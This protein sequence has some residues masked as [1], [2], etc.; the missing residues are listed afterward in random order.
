MALS[1]G[2][3]SVLKI[4]NK[5]YYKSSKF[6]DGNKRDIKLSVQIELQTENIVH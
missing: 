3:Y 6:I 5:N 1:N 2:T 4:G